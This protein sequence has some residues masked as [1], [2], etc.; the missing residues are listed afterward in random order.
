M[1]WT[2]REISRFLGNHYYRL[3][4]N[5]SGEIAVVD[6]NQEDDVPALKVRWTPGE[7]QI[8][9]AMRRKGKSFDEIAE[10]LKRTE[11]AVH[12]K[13][14]DRSEW[15]Q[16]VF[17]PRQ[18]MLTISDIC[19]AVCAVYQVE[20]V[21]FHSP[22]RKKKAVEARML[23]YWVARHYTSHSFPK[24]GEMI[25]ARDHTTV[26]HGVRKVEEQIDRFRRPIELVLFDLGLQ[27]KTAEAA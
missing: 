25:G 16:S 26:L 9:V 2:E 18:E 20:G 3:Q 15:M 14:K 11:T 8:L 12:Q 4:S 1:F 13:W 10:A 21:D 24:I 19:R 17:V 22:R 6:A 27:P 23:A 7:L 5:T